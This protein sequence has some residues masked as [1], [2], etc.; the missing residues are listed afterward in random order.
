MINQ[1]QHQL[2]KVR[3]FWK[4]IAFISWQENIQC[5]GRKLD[6]FFFKEIKKRNKQNHSGFFP[7]S[8]QW[9]RVQML[10]SIKSR[11]TIVYPPDPTVA[12]IH[13]LTLSMEWQSSEPQ[14]MGQKSKYR[15][16][17]SHMFVLEWFINIGICLISLSVQQWIITLNGRHCMYE[18]KWGDVYNSL[19][20]TYWLLTESFLYC[21]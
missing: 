16:E 21:W 20:I 13:I 5:F 15:L 6:V 11:N 7:I 2:C 3:K 1:Q 10:Q 8:I 17:E 19:D 12:S 4:G 14:I 18:S 9:V